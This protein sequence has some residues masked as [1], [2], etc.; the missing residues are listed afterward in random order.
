MVIHVCRRYGLRMSVFLGFFWCCA[1]PC[2]AT[3][4]S[5]DWLPSDAKFHLSILDYPE[6]SPLFK[7]T[8]LGKL[9]GDKA[10]KPFFDDF[11]SQLRSK[12]QATWPGLVW[13][14]LG[15]DWSRVSAI[16]SG[17]VA[18]AVFDVES[19]PAALFLADAT[20]KPEQVK[21][22]RDKIAAAMDDRDATRKELEVDGTT[23]KLYKLSRPDDRKAVRLIHFVRNGFFVATHNLELAKQIVPRVGVQQADSLS[24]ARR[25][26]QVLE[27]CRDA[28]STE[29]HAVLYAVPFSCLDL[30]YNVA[31][32]KEMEIKQSPKLYRELGFDALKAVG[33]TIVFGKDESDFS[34][35]ASLYAPK[36]WSKSMRMLDLRNG[37]GELR[38]WVDRNVSA[39]WFLNI[40][41]ESVY[42]NI[43]P[44]FDEVVAGGAPGAW[45]D[46]LV[47]LRED[48]YGPRIDLEKEVF[49]L[50]NGPAVVMEKDALPVTPESPRVLLAINATDQAALRAGIKKAMQDD[51]LILNKE[52]GN[53]PCYYAVSRDNE[54]Q[55]LWIIC[56]ARGHLFMANDFDI[57]T[58][59]LKSEVGIPLIE[60]S[61]F[62]QAKE[63]WTERLSEE[64]SAFTFHRLD[65]WIQVRYEL[66]RAGKRVSPRRSF[67]GM[68]SGFLGGERI[69]AKEPRIDGSR[70]PPFGQVR[71]YFGT[72]SAAA[73]TLDTGWIVC[74][75]VAR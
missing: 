65:R 7:Q 8:G 66:L 58:P 69:A 70:L 25:Y 43:G 56:V 29:P 57:L 68:L 12:A 41:A 31:T 44:F 28:S 38:R 51:P 39:C 22:L 37:I 14:D 45:E 73:A 55:L 40:Q 72:F 32:E 52:V 47:A 11:S 9:L 24:E 27:Q 59:I 15:V 1:A 48:E 10:I 6:S 75:R 53:T 17:E 21:L 60:Q 63:N 36:P 35:Y 30:A 20:G 2:L 67:V 18:W 23:L 50:L 26:R 64:P 34:F 13:V 46:V 42:E 54:D 19:S 16:P 33:A 5:S 61:D 62:Q 3:L 4:P 71:E 74:G 49:A